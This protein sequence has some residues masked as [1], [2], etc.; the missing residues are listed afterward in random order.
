MFA[1][2][3]AGAAVT[4]MFSAYGGIRWNSGLVR[5]L[6][7]ESG[8]TRIGGTMWD[9]PLRYLENS[10]IFFADKVKTPLLMMHN[11]ADGSVPWWQSIEMFTALHRLK[12][13]T[14]LLVY[15]GEDHNLRFRR[16]RK[17]LSVRLSQF[18]DHYLKDAP[19][20]IWMS[21]GVPAAKKGTTY[22]FELTDGGK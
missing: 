19:I 18:F 2:A 6:Q 9:Y 20:P 22:G 10:P 14:W 8:Q 7:Y 13:P 5:Q 1:A 16:N 21:E 15:N 17:D 12:K 4:N 11:D 3:G